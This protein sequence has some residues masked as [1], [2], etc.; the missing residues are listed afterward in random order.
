M[1]GALADLLGSES[2][3]TDRERAAYCLKRFTDGLN[4]LRQSNWLVQANINGIP[5]DTPSLYSHD[6]YSLEWQNNPNAWPVVVQAGVDLVGVCP[7]AACG[8]GMT[9]VGNSPIVDTS[10]V[11]LQVARDQWDV[12]LGYAQRLA[13]FKQGGESFAANEGME[14]DFYR[15]A[16]D[17]NERLLEMGIFTDILHTAGQR[18]D[19]SVSRKRDDDAEFKQQQRAVIAALGGK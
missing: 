3:K 12:V 4:I 10:G 16:Q 9:L 19:E 8:V 5:C 1:W 2:E 14:M 18:E 6:V 13:T 7:V 15:A 11:Y 17:T